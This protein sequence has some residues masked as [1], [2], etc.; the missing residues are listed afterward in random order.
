MKRGLVVALLSAAVLV[1]AAGTASADTTGKLGVGFDQMLGG[2]TG[3]TGRYFAAPKLSIQAV[4]SYDLVDADAGSTSEFDLGLRGLYA[5][6]QDESFQLDLGGGLNIIRSSVEV[7]GNS[8]SNTKLAIE[9]GVGPTWWAT[10]H[11]ALNLFMG[12]LIDLDADGNDG[13]LIGLFE[14]P[15]FLGQ[16]GFIWIIN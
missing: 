12:V 5:I 7:G 8:E 3:L 16:A 13:T 14:P 15:T 6:L 9:L 10:D 4:L 11:F 2:A 1:G